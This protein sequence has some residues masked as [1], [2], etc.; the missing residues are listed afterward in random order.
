MIEINRAPFTLVVTLILM[1]TGPIFK[2]AA[3]SGQ[4]ARKKQVSVFLPKDGDAVDPSSNPSNLHPVKRSVDAATPLRPAL[5]ALLK[6]PTPREARQGFSGHDVNGMY[7]V[8]VAV[9]NGTAY[10]SFAHRRSWAGWSGDLSPL[11]FGDGV[12]RTMK[13]FPGV[14]RTVVCVD[15]VVNFGDESGGPEQKCPDF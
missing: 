11:A 10:A 3:Q 13:Q 12:E 15:G 9:K 2:T 5:E 14:L 6:G 8:K 4:P 1:T 7:I